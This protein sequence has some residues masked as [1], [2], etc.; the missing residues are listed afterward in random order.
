MGFSRCEALACSSTLSPQCLYWPVEGA[1]GSWAVSFGH[2]L[3][4]HSL[5]PYKT[6]LD[7]WPLIS[8]WDSVIMNCF[9][10]PSLLRPVS[11]F[12]P[13][14]LWPAVEGEMSLSLFPERQGKGFSVPN[15]YPLRCLEQLMK[16]L[17]LYLVVKGE[18]SG[19]R[20]TQVETQ[21]LVF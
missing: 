15:S 19:S 9:E 13:P 5:I 16:E 21:R 10:F 20:G 2:Y 4:L 17:W 12:P 6:D 14:T 7:F 18:R 1:L 11:F 3:F 8:L